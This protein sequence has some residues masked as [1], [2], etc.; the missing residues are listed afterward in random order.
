MSIDGEYGLDGAEFMLDVDLVKGVIFF[1]CRVLQQAAVLIAKNN[2]IQLSFLIRIDVFYALK[3]FNSEH[4]DDFQRVPMQDSQVGLV[5]SNINMGLIGCNCAD[6]DVLV[7]E[8]V[9][10]RYFSEAFFAVDL[11][12]GE[13][14]LVENVVGAVV[15]GGS[16]EVQALRLE[17]IW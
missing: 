10:K 3:A 6:F 2:H 8:V 7:V 12:V 16:G 4:P 14:V 15:E 1:V 5:E 13:A 9:L 17:P 11:L